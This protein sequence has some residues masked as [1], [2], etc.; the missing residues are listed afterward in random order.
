MAQITKFED[1]KTFIE[2]HDPIVVLDVV[3]LLY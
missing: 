2:E 3:I 1:F